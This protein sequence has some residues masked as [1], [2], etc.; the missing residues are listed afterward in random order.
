MVM[1]DGETSIPGR[2]VIRALLKPRW[3]YESASRRFEVGS[4][5]FTPDKSLPPRTRIEMVAPRLQTTPH[6]SLS[7]AE[8][9]LS[10][11]VQIVLPQKADPAEYVQELMSWPC[12][13]EV[14]ISAPPSL[15]SV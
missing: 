14:Y 6:E 1:L 10:R 8:R 5:R 13:E 7:A 3:R 2:P 4:R 12:F 15:P 11:W 9:K